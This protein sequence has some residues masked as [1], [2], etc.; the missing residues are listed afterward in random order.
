MRYSPNNRLVSNHLKS[1]CDE[2]PKQNPAATSHEVVGQPGKINPIAAKTTKIE[3]QTIQMI[4]TIGFLLGL[5]SD[6]TASTISWSVR[7]SYDAV[8]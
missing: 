1:G 7:S 6:K 3:P 5:C 4:L 8:P 2:R